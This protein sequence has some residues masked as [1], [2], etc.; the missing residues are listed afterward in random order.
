MVADNEWLIKAI[1]QVEYSAF[2]TSHFSI[3]HTSLA[4]KELEHAVH[5]E[6]FQFSLEISFFKK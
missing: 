2:A 3:E 1:T 6:I 4:T 5:S